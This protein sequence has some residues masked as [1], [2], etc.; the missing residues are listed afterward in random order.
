VHD[1]PQGAYRKHGHPAETI[2]LAVVAA[3]AAEAVLPVTGAPGWVLPATEII[4][5]WGTGAVTWSLTGRWRPFPAYTAALGTFLGGWTIWAQ[6]H[7]LWH[8][9]TFG[10]LLA[11]M[12]VMVPWGVS[13]WHGRH[14]RTTQ[15]LM[16][17]AAPE[18]LM[19][20]PEPDPAE[21]QRR[22]QMDLFAMMFADF[23]IT[24]GK[25]PLT[26]E[27]V[28]VNVTGLT[29]ERWG[30]QVRIK[31]PRSG[32]VT[33]EDFRAR[34]KN[35]E[36]SLEVQEEAVTFESDRAEV[37]MK[38]RERDGMAGTHRL[39][40]ELRARSVNEEVIVGV[41][42]DGSYLRVPIREVHIMM[43][44][45]TGSG[46]SNLVNVLIA[47]LASCVDTVIWAIDMKGGRAIRPWF[48]AW[49]EGRAEAPTVDWIATTRAE[50]EMMMNAVVTATETRMRSGKGRSKIKPTAS[51][52]QIILF[53]DEMAGLF[54][55]AKGVRSEIGEDAKSQQWFIRRGGD[56]TQLGRS[57]A[58]TTIWASQRGTTSMGASTD[59]KANIDVRFALRPSQLSE[60]QWIVPDLPSLATRQLTFLA[61]TP[62]VG[63][64]GRG[65]HASQPSKFLHHDHI[66]GVCGKDEDSPVC[67]P[68]CPVYQTQLETAPVRPR[69]DQMTAAALGADYAQRWVRAQRDGILKVPAKALS[70]GSA[71]YGSRGSAATF[72]EVT[73]GI[74]DPEAG[75]HPGH[76]RMLEYLGSCGRVGTNVS[77][78]MAV[79]EHEGIDVARETVHRWLAAARDDSRV[80]HPSYRRWVRGP[81]PNIEGE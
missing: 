44:G 40:P 66:E 6:S 65:P 45:S 69:L 73:R 35:F 70:G 51:L 59:M 15:P 62:G 29:E 2:G 78:I 18:P 24:A 49:E 19:T 50:A 5:A 80:H 14:A 75:M 8:W 38:I 60:L 1:E 20:E 23:G 68:E 31:L 36:V 54:G 42:E 27:S 17:E 41:Q 76:V 81:G 58:V 46:K 10:V 12:A 4:T 26:G 30:R 28:P 63:M 52:P 47:Q 37:V 53:C 11:G 13:S 21:V 25:D 39:T 7:G 56:V 77:K 67:P 34:S 55:D 61:Q 74:P 32:Q 22:Q 9:G 16:L 3:A 48:Q 72:E 64:M 57:E 71:S 33:V 43:V 79:L